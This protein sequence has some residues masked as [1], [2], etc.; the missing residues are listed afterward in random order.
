MCNDYTYTENPEK[1]G[2]SR[3]V[4]RPHF[5]WEQPRTAEIQAL[6]RERFTWVCS[7]SRN[8]DNKR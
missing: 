2:D 3:W 8:Y 1:D 4:H 5:D 6:R 7:E